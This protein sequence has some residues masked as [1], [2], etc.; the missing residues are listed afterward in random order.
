MERKKKGKLDSIP[1]GEETGGLDESMEEGMAGGGGIGGG[2]I[3]AIGCTSKHKR[4][5]V[6]CDLR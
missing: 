5:I 1:E 2:D 3:G 6:G 4:S